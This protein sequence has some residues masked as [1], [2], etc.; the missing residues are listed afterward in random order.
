M[1]KIAFALAVLAVLILSSVSYTDP[2][3][4]ANGTVPQY[5]NNVW[6][7]AVSSAEVCKD[8]EVVDRWYSPYRLCM[9]A[10]CWE[11]HI[12]ALEY[13]NMPEDTNWQE[14][15]GVARI[16]EKG[17]QDAYYYE[18]R[19]DVLYLLDFEHTEPV[20]ARGVPLVSGHSYEWDARVICADNRWSDW[21]GWEDFVAQ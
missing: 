5:E 15:V 18:I 4:P 10:T 12:L 1:P 14:I 7:P 2:K 13:S 9:Q 21:L 17:L 8:A 19:T 3:E 6:L 20:G 16:R 11:W